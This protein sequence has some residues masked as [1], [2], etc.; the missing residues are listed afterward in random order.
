MISYTTSNIDIERLSKYSLL[1]NS[2]ST[3]QTC[4]QYHVAT[5]CECLFCGFHAQYALTVSF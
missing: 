2:V 5:I 4:E 3:Q 1:E